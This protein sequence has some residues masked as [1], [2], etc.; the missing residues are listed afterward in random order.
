MMLAFAIGMIG[1][2]AVTLHSY[3]EVGATV[4]GIVGREQMPARVRV[5]VRPAD[6]RQAAA[7][8]R[9]ALT[10]KLGAD[11][12]E[13]GLATG[14]STGAAGEAHIGAAAG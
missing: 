6:P 11:T 7:A 13:I 3:Y 2:Y 9:E 4:L 8:L 12:R 14:R 1:G 10:E 5:G